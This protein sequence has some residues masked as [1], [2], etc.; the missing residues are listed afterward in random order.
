MK[1]ATILAAVLVAAPQ[2][3]PAAQEEFRWSG[4]VALGQ[5]DT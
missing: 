3:A 2:L 5:T 1:R 4:K